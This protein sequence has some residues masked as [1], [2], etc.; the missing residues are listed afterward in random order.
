MFGASA[1]RTALEAGDVRQL[2]RISAAQEPHLPRLTDAQAE[3][4]M[5]DAR[6]RARSMPLAK[7][8]WSHR[9]LTE[10]GHDSGLPDQLRPS[11]EQVTPRIVAAV[12]ISYQNKLERDLPGITAAVGMKMAEAVQ[13]AQADGR[14]EDSIFVR[15]RIAQARRKALRQFLGIRKD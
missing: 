8:L 7:R 2:Q 15:A 5:H 11:A 6:T 3:V 1:F 4:V 12:G 14:L 13:E 9:W 10:R